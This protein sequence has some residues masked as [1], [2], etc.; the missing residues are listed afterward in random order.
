[1]GIN[2][3]INS[4]FRICYAYKEDQKGLALS[5]QILKIYCRDK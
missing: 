1:M 5:I 2:N 4:N 3:R